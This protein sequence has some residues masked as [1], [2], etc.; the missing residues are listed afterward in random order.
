M[1]IPI[2]RGEILPAEAE[3]TRAEALGLG[4]I[5]F[6]I[7]GRNVGRGGLA[8]SLTVGDMIYMNQQARRAVPNITPIEFPF[9]R[10]R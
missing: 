2:T 7:H 10:A 9:R 6:P 1:G 8:D 5:D 4:G 3:I